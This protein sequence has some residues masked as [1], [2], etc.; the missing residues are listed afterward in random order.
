[1]ITFPLV[2][3]WRYFA[4]V[5]GHIEWYW[6]VASGFPWFAFHTD[7]GLAYVMFHG[8]VWSS[9]PARRRGASACWWTSR[10]PRCTPC[11]PS[12]WACATVESCRGGCTLRARVVKTIR[13]DTIFIA[14]P[15]A[16]PK[17]A[18]QP[19]IAAQEPISKIPEFKVCAGRERPAEAPPVY[20]GEL[21][22]Q[23]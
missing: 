5:P 10:A 14:Y 6:V 23:Q 16:G 3:G 18:N 21:E 1:M 2:F 13:P 11:W 22:P 12:A 7:F 9:F 17:G 19:T 15:W 4:P 20:A 8:L